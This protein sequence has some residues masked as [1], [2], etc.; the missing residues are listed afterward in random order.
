MLV[1]ILKPGLHHNRNGAIIL[2]EP[3]D[4]K[5]LVEILV[6]VAY[7]CEL[8]GVLNV[9]AALLMKTGLQ[10]FN[11]SSTDYPTDLS[12]INLKN[13]YESIY[14]LSLFVTELFIA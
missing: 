4:C 2:T 14:L 6:Y 3:F 5:R 10:Y 13:F 11:K 7:S 8:N 9:I 1:E 12:H